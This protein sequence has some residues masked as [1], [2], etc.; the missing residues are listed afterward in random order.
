[1]HFYFKELVDKLIGYK[2]K[3]KKT[4]KTPQG[5]INGARRT[6]F[7]HCVYWQLHPSLTPNQL[8]CL[9]DHF[10]LH[11]SIKIWRPGPSKDADPELRPNK[12]F[13]LCVGVSLQSHLGNL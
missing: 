3:N 13:K 4:T 7:Y 12:G 5:T 9:S 6:S 11:S 8:L 2:K 1:M 10:C